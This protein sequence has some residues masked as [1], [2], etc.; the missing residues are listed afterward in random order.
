MLI[1]VYILLIGVLS[2]MYAGAHFVN[3]LRMREGAKP[4]RLACVAGRA[5]I[6]VALPLY[7]CHHLQLISPRGIN[8]LVRRGTRLPRDYI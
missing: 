2:L 1:K 7:F 6:N 8:Y 5:K 4:S 3:Y